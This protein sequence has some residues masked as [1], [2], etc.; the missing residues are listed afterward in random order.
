MFKLY[1]SSAE[2]LCHL[3]QLVHVYHMFKLY[4][5]SAETLCH[6][7]QLVHVYQWSNSIPWWELSWVSVGTCWS[8]VKL[9]WSSAETPGCLCWNVLISNQHL[10]FLDKNSGVFKL[11]HAGACSSVVSLLCIDGNSGMFTFMPVDHQPSCV[12]PQWELGCLSCYTLKL[13]LGKFAGP[14][15]FVLL[16]VIVYPSV[17]KR[18]LSSR[19]LDQFIFCVCACLVLSSWF[20]L[21]FTDHDTNKESVCFNWFIWYITFFP[22]WFF[23]FFFSVLISLQFKHSSFFPTGISPLNHHCFFRHFVA[24]VLVEIWYF[25]FLWYMVVVAGWVGGVCVCRLVDVHILHLVT[26]HNNTFHRLCVYVF[27]LPDLSCT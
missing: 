21:S 11:E 12:I 16:E 13:P 2:T 25:V 8:V 5:S 24:F 15:Q 4:C 6:L 9:W 18:V 14:H 22:F 10:L 1:C 19:N 3:N 17:V 26:A 23:S 20:V 27:I 7:N